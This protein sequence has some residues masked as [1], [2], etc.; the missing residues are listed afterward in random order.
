MLKLKLQFFG[1]LIQ[2]T[3]S[4]EKT[5]MLEKIEGRRRRWQ[6]MRWLDNITNSMHM[7]LSKL[8]ELVTE[9]E[10]YRAVVDGAAESQTRLSDWTELTPISQA[11]HSYY[12]L[13]ADNVFSSFTGSQI[14]RNLVP[15][16]IIWRFSPLP[17][18]DSEIWMRFRVLSWCRKGLRL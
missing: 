14:K 3:D 15:V 5:L 1:C 16:W 12:I 4:F 8:W 17:E 11:V 18:V 9:R 10:A 2:R 13:G 7:S 6:R